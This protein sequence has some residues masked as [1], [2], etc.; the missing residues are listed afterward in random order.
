MLLR[1]SH[2][3]YG[4]IAKCF[5]W[6]MA[7]AILAM[8][9]IGFKMTDLP[10]SPDKFR[11]Y[12]IHKSIG[13]LILITAFLRLFWRFINIVPE[14]PADMPTWQKLGAHGSHVALY[15]VM[16]VMPLSGWLM[17]SAAGFPV[18]VFGWFLL[19]N[20]I[21][22]DS[23]LRPIFG[24]AHEVL[25]F[26]IIGLVSL[27]I[28]AALKH[29]FIDKDNILRR[30]LP[31]VLLPLLVQPL[32]AAETGPREW[33]VIGDKSSLEFTATQNDAL[34]KGKLNMFHTGI[35]FSPEY[36]EK[37]TILVQMSVKDIHIDYQ[38]AQQ[39]I[40]SP[41]WLDGMQFPTMYFRSTH[42]THSDGKNYV[43]EGELSIRNITLPIILHFTLEEYADNHA[44]AKGEATI[45]RT[46]YG[47]GRGEWKATDIIKDEV[48]IQLDLYVQDQPWS[49]P[50]K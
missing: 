48:A 31:F 4:A 27:H 42:I 8:L 20:L 35:N 49:P 23:G 5:H 14:L 12:G 36:L 38:P 50:A 21:A 45:S 13:A 37:S 3:K 1:N 19:P 15:I 9:V 17:S 46:A 2:E 32:H 16:F 47:I 40:Q 39:A 26:V 6:V 33:Y 7:L 10:I 30:M 43:A 28:L 44:H 25:A 24:F 18:S 34:I 11:I 29:H 22:P 41:D